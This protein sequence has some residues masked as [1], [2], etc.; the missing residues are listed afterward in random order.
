MT[1]RRWLLALCAFFSVSMLIAGCGS[2]S[3]PSGSVVDVSCNTVTTR[4]FNHWMYIAAKGQTQSNPGA[5]LVVPNDP[6]DF[7]GC[8]SQVRKQLPNLAKVPSKQLK[9]TCKQLFTSLSTQVLD[10]LIRAYWYQADAA[11]HHMSVSSKAVQNAFNRDI[12]Q[13]FGGSQTAFKKAVL[14]PSGQT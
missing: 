7:N 11:K 9:A 4:A 6:P 12:Q 13:Q 3:V 1:F 10:F 14:T 2:S 8:V 5:P